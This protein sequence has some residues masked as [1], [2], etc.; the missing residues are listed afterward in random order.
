MTPLRLRD[1]VWLTLTA[2]P[3]VAVPCWLLYW[4]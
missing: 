1:V 3:L 4:L 2:L